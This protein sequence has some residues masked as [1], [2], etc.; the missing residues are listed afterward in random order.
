[1]SRL[2]ESD[3]DKI[4]AKL[5]DYDRLFCEQ[6]G[7][8]MEKL[9][10]K[11]I[12]L[13]EKTDKPK[14]AVIPVTSG[15]GIIG[16]FSQTVAAILRFCRVETV[17]T[18]ATDVAGLQQAYLSKCGVAF[19]ADDNVC[20]AFSIGS[21]AHSDNGFATGRGFAAA[22]TAAMRKRAICPTGQ[23]V[24][25]IGAGPVGKAAAQYLSEQGAIP[26]IC[27][28]DITKA[29]DAATTIKGAEWINPP[30]G[31][32]QYA[33]IVDAS[34]AG[35]FITE[36]NVTEDTIIAAPGMPCGVI[37]AAAKKATVIHNPLELGIIAMYFDCVRQMGG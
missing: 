35:D 21:A 25:I 15:L 12:G 36:E 26:V 7:Y 3:I 16:G 4:E 14:T 19:L 2:T 34:T 24:L 30:A 32:N 5:Q 18:E 6:T 29:A 28:L 33:Y 23:R 17:I 8:T 31:I 20:A 13:T 11:A 22:L 10:K 9:A 27:D 37:A 1:M